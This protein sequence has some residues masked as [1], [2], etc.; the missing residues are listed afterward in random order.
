M[1]VRACCN[2]SICLFFFCFLIC[3]KWSFYLYFYKNFPEGSAEFAA[4]S[5]RSQAV[6]IEN[7]WLQPCN[8]QGTCI[9]E[10]C[11]LFSLWNIMLC[12]RWII[13]FRVNWCRN[14]KKFE[15]TGLGE[16]LCKRSERAT[17]KPENGSGRKF[18]ILW[19]RA[20]NNSLFNTLKNRGLTICILFYQNFPS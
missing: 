4:C 6:P 19:I 1:L 16:T 10:N 15:L 9:G 7:S 14:G 8:L 11:K 2:T 20:S 5:L 17:E 12:Y 18:Y 3:K 13:K